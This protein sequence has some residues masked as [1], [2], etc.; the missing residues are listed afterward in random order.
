MARTGNIHIRHAGIQLLLLR[1]YWGY[2][3]YIDGSNR[4]LGDVVRP[5]KEAQIGWSASRERD[6]THSMAIYRYDQHGLKT[7]KAAL[8]V[9]INYAKMNFDL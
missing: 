7:R 5:Q 9:C 4:Y 2:E 6:D 1:Y 8:D 3:V